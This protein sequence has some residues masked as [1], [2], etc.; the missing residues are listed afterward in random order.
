[1]Y[2]GKGT[3]VFLDGQFI[4]AEEAR[5]DLFSQTLHYG[6]GVI[7]GMRSYATPMGAHI[8]KARAHY[9]RLLECA[10]KLGWKVEYSLEELIHYSY[11]LLEENNTTEESAYI[12]PIIF[13]GANMA[14]L[15]SSEVHVGI[16]AWKWKSYFENDQ[17]KLWISDIERPNPKS[18]LI[19]YKITGH[20]TNY[21][22]A[23]N[24]ARKKGYDEALLLDM[25]GNV[26]QASASNFFYQKNGKLYTA[27]QGHIMPGITRAL[28]MNLATE[29]GYEVIEKTSKPEELRGAEGA[30]L[31]SAALEITGVQSINGKQS[32]LP[33][34]ETIGYEILLKYRQIMS[35]AQF[36]S[37]SII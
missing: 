25:E 3:T 15:N 6:H 23:T 26:S 16:A 17:L 33:W 8:F 22:L 29:L 27:P 30:F 11:Q 9:S 34:E 14:L 37:Y 28:V 36:D 32:Q 20:Y 24:E 4:K 1:M 13:M 5:T 35:Q 2:Y 31:T 10:E 18:T 19:D 12:R 21:I 7:E